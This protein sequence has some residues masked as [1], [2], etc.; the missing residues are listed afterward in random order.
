MKIQYLSGEVSGRMGKET[1]ILGD[2]VVPNQIIGVADRVDVPLLDEVTWDGILGLAYP[3]KNLKSQNIDPLVDNIIRQNI[4]VNRGE[5]NQFSYYLG[6]D[7]G[8][9]VFGGV[10]LRY[11]RTAKE[12]FVYAPITSLDYWTVKI[13]DVRVLRAGEDDVVNRRKRAPLCPDG[14]KTIIDTGTY[15]IYGPE[16]QFHRVLREV[17]VN[18]CDDRAN[19]PSIVLEIFGNKDSTGSEQVVELVLT[20]DDYVLEFDM[21]GVTDCVLGIAPDTEDTGWTLGQVFL[22]S[23]LTVFDRDE[24]K[25]GFVRSNMNPYPLPGQSSKRSLSFKQKL[26]KEIFDSMQN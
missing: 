2:L 18:S 7:M 11:K 1:I 3:N 9:V 4:L 26:R 13:S 15:L 14:C 16:E 17:E 23:F 25:I 8:S 10:D 22:K 12:E 6:P 21:N 5:K 24:G 19:L 20:P